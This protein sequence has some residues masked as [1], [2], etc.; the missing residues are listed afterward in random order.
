M[1]QNLLTDESILRQTGERLAQRRIE[2]GLTQAD[3][4]AEAGIGRAT[5]ER[6]EAGRSTQMSSFVRVLRVLGLLEEFLGL[7]P[8]PGPGPMD[9]LKKRPK[10]RQRASTRRNPGEEQET[11]RWSDDS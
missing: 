8:E 11:W 3:L 7:V 1:N 4:A 9:L 6:L 5:V 10:V 2:N